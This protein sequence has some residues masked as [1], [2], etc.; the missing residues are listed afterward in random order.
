MDKIIKDRWLTVEGDKIAPLGKGFLEK[1]RFVWGRGSIMSFA[2][3]SHLRT[4]IYR[5]PQLR[6]WLLRK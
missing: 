5:S 4:H 2:N 3:S 1:G 6:D